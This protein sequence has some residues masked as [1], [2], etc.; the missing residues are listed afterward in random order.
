MN[1]ADTART[2]ARAL[3]ANRL[4]SLLTTLGI[5]IGVAAVITMLAVGEGARRQVAEELKSLG[6]N[7]LLVLPGTVTA[8]GVRLGAGSRNTLTERDARAI[9]EEIGSV[10]AAGAALR[11]SGQLVHGNLNWSSQIFG[12]TPDYLVARDWKVVRGRSLDESD[13]RGSSQVALV[14]QTVADMLFGGTDPTGQILRVKQVPFT[15]VGLLAPKGQSMMGQDQD[16]MVAIPI[17]AARGRILGS[18]AGRPDSVGHIYVK[19]KDG[20]DMAAG[21]AAVRELLRQRHRL[22]PD[23]E[24]DFNLRNLSEVVAAE[25]AASRALSGLLAAIA[26]VSLLVGGIGIMNI[27]LVSVTERTREIGI[28]LAVGARGR[29]ILLQFLVEAIILA[30]IGG[31][32][33][34]GLGIAASLAVEHWL[35]WP[36]VFQAHA[37]LLAV[38]SAMAVGIFFGWYP[39]RKAAR[40]TPIQALRYE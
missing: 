21:E 29:D 40:L 37:V 6:S 8:S 28:R 22:Q 13:A 26:S 36:V 38:G 9:Q 3:R 7:L 10:L 27:M 1:L 24:D 15:I 34:I 19:F 14:G 4:R 5:I 31:L 17:A 2:A 30:L 39:A 11:G 33:G 32:A 18:P 25:Q 20:A 12:V 35:A 16:D 23:Q